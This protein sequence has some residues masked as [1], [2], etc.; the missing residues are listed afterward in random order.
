MISDVILYWIEEF[1]YVAF[2]LLGFIGTTFT[3]LPDPVLFFSSGFFA[4]DTELSMSLTFLLC[5]IGFMLS[6]Y[7]KYLL[8]RLFS[9]RAM[10]YIEKKPK[11]KKH[12]KRSFFLLEKF[13][14]ISIPISYFV[15]ILRHVLPIALGISKYS[16]KKYIFISFGFGFLWTLIL[17]FLGSKW[18]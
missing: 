8:G 16:H 13:G 1:G 6:L 12:A 11:R 9:E 3:P 4:I 7:S 2:F 18:S 5:Y 14:G 17:F 10:Q 15:P